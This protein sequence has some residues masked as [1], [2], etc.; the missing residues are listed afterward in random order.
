MSRRVLQKVDGGGQ[1]PVVDLAAIDIGRGA[2]P[3]HPFRSGR[4][5]RQNQVGAGAAAAG[6]SSSSKR[7]APISRPAV[8]A[9]WNS[10]G[11]SSRS[12]RLHVLFAA[13]LFIQVGIA[14]DAVLVGPDAAADGGV[15]G[16]GDRGHGA[17][18]GAEETGLAPPR[19]HRHAAVFQIVEPEPVAHD[20]HDALRSAFGA[21]PARQASVTPDA[22]NWRRFDRRRVPII[23]YS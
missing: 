5:R 17:L 14:G 21:R 8:W 9:R 10:V 16:V 7:A 20:D 1:E 22:R 2:E 3:L 18:N 12:A 19:E 23:S 6:W 11:A 15:V 13:G 4:L